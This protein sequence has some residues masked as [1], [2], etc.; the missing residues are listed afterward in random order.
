MKKLKL[1]S[2]VETTLTIWIVT[3]FMLLTLAL[4]MIRISELG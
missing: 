1:R 2:W 4:Y 3:D